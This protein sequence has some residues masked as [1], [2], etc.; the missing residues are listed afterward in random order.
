MQKG[1]FPL[2]YC[3]YLRKSRADA[4]AEARGEG[5]TL[6]RHKQTLLALAQN[7]H[8]PIGEIYQEVVSGETI[9]GRPVM[10]KLLYD[11]EK[12]CWE[13]VLVMEVERLARGD[14]MDQGLVAQTFKYAGAKIITPSKVYDPN[15][16]FDEEY[17][18]FGLFMSRREYKTI[19][20]RLQNGRLASVKEGKY[21]GS[22]APYGYQKYKLPQEKGYSLE[23][24][25]EE[26]ELVRFIFQ[27]Y[28]TGEP[29]IN[30]TQRPLGAE[31]IARRLNTLQTLSPR[32][33]AWSASTIRD[34]LKNPVYIGQIR[35]NW[36]PVHKK[37]QEGQLVKERPRSQQGDYLMIEG[38]HPAIIDT[39]TWAAAQARMAAHATPPVGAN[40][41]LQ[42][43]L[44]GLI[45]CSFCGR[46]LIRRPAAQ[47]DKP[48]SLLCPNPTCKNRSTYLPLVETYILATLDQWLP[49]F[50]LPAPQE[51]TFS[52]SG[53]QELYIKKIAAAQK[54]LAAQQERLYDLLEQGVYTPELFATRQQTLAKQ[55]A[56]L[57]QNQG[58]A[59]ASFQQ[60][61]FPFTPVSAPVALS[62]QELYQSLPD[63]TTKNALLK[64]ILVQIIYTK[65]DKR[66]S[67]SA[68]DSFHLRLYPKISGSPT[69]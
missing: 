27:L 10:Q 39:A 23:I 47:P 36:R 29:Q 22:Q 41:K 64:A 68:S 59:E 13:G 67:G 8:F 26:A 1:G 15:N 43:P 5:E 4:E 12:G 63:I 37:M 60:K 33:E 2:A 11:I 51:L 56:Q 19:N 38:R 69:S 57:Q 52:H 34:I 3:L 9:A 65:T 21:V 58:L 18:E 66:H 54:K 50:T 46:Q 35:W 55:M 45:R 17:F 20:R 32:K 61:L 24:L 42:N 40:K 14:T 48:A 28:T 16:E 6:S 49:P 7:R 25:P 30:G 44:A 62:F 31:L 53:K